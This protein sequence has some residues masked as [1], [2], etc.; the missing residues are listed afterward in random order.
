MKVAI[1]ATAVAPAK[2]FPMNIWVVDLPECEIDQ[3]F[4]PTPDQ[5]IVPEEWFEQANDVINRVQAEQVPIVV[6]PPE[7]WAE[8]GWAMVDPEAFEVDH[9]DFETG[10]LVYIANTLVKY[11]SIKCVYDP[12][13]F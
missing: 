13:W 5:T 3:A 8:K 9:N 11:T 7:S 2:T 12:T 10:A 1:F 6:N 4:M